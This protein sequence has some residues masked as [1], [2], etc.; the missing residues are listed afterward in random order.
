[1]GT[2]TSAPGRPGFEPEVRLTTANP[3]AKVFPDPVGARPQTSRPLSASGSVGLL[4]GERVGQAAG[5]Q[6][7]NQ[8]GANPEIGNE[9][10]T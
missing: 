6:A 1:M 4:D 10:V 5:V 3:K 2:R 7:G 8:V 9:T